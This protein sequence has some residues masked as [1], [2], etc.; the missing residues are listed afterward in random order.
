MQFC[1]VQ[2]SV[3]QRKGCVSY[4]Y[5]AVARERVVYLIN[6][7]QWLSGNC[8]AGSRFWQSG[9]TQCEQDNRVQSSIYI[10]V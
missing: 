5:L 6:I 2:L 7:L 4:Q 8:W 1:G 3:G 10:T 9:F